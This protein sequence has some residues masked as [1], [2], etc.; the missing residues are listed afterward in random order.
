MS[1]VQYKITIYTYTHL[2]VPQIKFIYKHICTTKYKIICRDFVSHED[3]PTSMS[4]YPIPSVLHYIIH[5]LELIQTP[6]PG[7]CNSEHT[8]NCMTRTV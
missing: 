6:I 2:P 7:V 5:N 3:N 4:K 1:L 8:I